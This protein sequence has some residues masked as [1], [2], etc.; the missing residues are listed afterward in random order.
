MKKIIAPVIVSLCMII[1]IISNTLNS[2]YLFLG[3]PITPL[4][5]VGAIILCFIVI[6]TLIQRIREIKRGELDDIDNY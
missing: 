3:T 1:Y 6:C 5:V 4:I 2:S